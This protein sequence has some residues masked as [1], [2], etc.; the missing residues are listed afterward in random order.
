MNRTQTAIK[1]IGLGS[2]ILGGLLGGQSA[3][4]AAEPN[5]AMEQVTSVSQLSDVRPNDW[6]FQAL[7]SLVERYGCIVGYPDKTFRG[8]RALSRYE[9]AAGLNACMDWV[10]ELIAASTTDLVKKEDLA[11]LQ[12]LQEQFAAELATLRGRVD[13]LEART[14][15]LEKQQFSTTTKLTGEAIFAVSDIFGNQ[16]RDFGNNTVFQDRVRLNLQTSFTGRDRLNTRL[17]AGNVN[18]FFGASSILS[19][20]VGNRGTAQG[21]LAQRVG[22]ETG[23]S[24][25]LDRL[26]YSFPLGDRLNFYVAAAGGKNSYVANPVNPFYDDDGGQGSISAFGQQSPIYR[27]GGGAGA[28]VS[29]ALDSRKTFVISGSYLASDANSPAS[30]QGLFGGNYAAMGQLT[31]QPTEAIQIGLTYVNAYHRPGTSL[32]NS[33]FGGNNFFTGTLPANSLHTGF[34]VPAVTN[35]Y[36]LEAAVKLSPSFFVSGFG[37]YTNLRLARTGEADIWYYALG[38]GFPDLFKRGN[39]GGIIVGAE[40]YVDSLNVG[41]RGLRDFR[42]GNSTSLH[43]EAFYRYQVND[44]LSITPGVIWVTNPDQD[45]RNSD[46]VIGTIRTTFSF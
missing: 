11:T 34:N 44:R 17:A 29:F 36:G 25:V 9:F 31:I 18:Q 12:K 20:F 10:N 16:A 42:L 13:S 43:V 5:P 21:A 14:A 6:A 37:G 3:L 19:P 33:G 38:L 46:Y 23:N 22:G 1:G 27:I 4:L 32:F 28:G 30:K 40:P 24:V 26:D 41:G 35:S 45:S 8:N 7:Q 39:L 2:A 15:T